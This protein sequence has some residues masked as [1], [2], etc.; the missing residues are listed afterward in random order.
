MAGNLISPIT[1]RILDTYEQ[2]IGS[3]DDTDLVYLHSVLAQ[4]RL[5]HRDPKDT[6]E[7][8]K[9]VGYA[10]LVVQAEYLMNEKQSEHSM[11]ER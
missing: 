5:P 6:T 4:V 1:Q 3:P 11:G 10:S 8:H 7:C 9:Q 2:I